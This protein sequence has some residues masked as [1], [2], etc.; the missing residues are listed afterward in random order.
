MLLWERIKEWWCEKFGHS[1]DGK[2]W[3]YNGHRHD[4]CLRCRRIISA[5]APAPQADRGGAT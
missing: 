1:M 3:W 2:P 5:P 4:V